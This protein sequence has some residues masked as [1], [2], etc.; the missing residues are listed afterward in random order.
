MEPAASQLQGTTLYVVQNRLNQIAVIELAPALSSGT[1][2]GHITN[3]DFDVPTTL[4]R[5]GNALYTVNARFGE[6][7][8]E[9]LEY[10][11][12]RVLRH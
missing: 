5:F 8:P 4:A 6:P 9:A 11:V 1:I 7:S 3:P 2:V 12:V 10:D